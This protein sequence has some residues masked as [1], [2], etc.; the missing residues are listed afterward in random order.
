MEGGYK[1][2]IKLNS[3]HLMPVNGLGT[4]NIK[5]P[6]IYYESVKAGVRLFDT[7]Q[8][9]F[10]E[11]ELGEGLKLALSEGIVKREELFITTK[12]WVSSFDKP[13]ETIKQQLKDLQLDYVDLYLL[14]WPLRSYNKEKNEFVKIPMYK[15]WG[16]MESLVKKGYT[17]SI[18]VSNFN[19]QS[20]IDMFTYCEIMPAVNQFEA[21]PYFSRTG[22]VNF[23]NKFGITVMAYGSLVKGL[24]TS[25]HKTETEYDLLNEKIVKD[26]AKKYNKSEGQIALNWGISKGFVVIPKSSN[27]KRMRDNLDATNFKMSDED[28]K[29]LDKLECG[30]RFCDDIDRWEDFGQVDIF[31]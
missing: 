9:Y 11:K 24:Y 15:L 20:L 18:G 25:Q 26:L 3:G 29:E 30:K 22:L 2:N 19:V 28:L 4:Y 31:A 5:D 8:F 1:T 14:H 27:P 21:H 17:K 16:E 12:L 13:E 10:N 23:C 7:A 6:Q